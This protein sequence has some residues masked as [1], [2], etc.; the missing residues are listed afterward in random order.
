MQQR[1]FAAKAAHQGRTFAPRLG[2][3]RALAPARADA[4]ALCL[5]GMERP[6]L[7]SKARQQ[8]CSVLAFR[9]PL[10]R[11]VAY[12]LWPAR[13]R[14]TLHR[15]CAAFLEQH[16][17]KCQSCG[18]GDFVA[19]HRFAVTSTQDGG[20]C[21]SPAQQG[22]FCSW[23]ALVLAGGQLKRNRIHDT[24]GM[25]CTVLRSPGPPGAQ[26]CVLGIGWE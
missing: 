14:G 9:V 20:S 22:D 10:L 4:K 5:A 26:G 25:L 15:K 19:F 16:A 2:R 12:E 6:C 24:E 1:W 21:Q 11:E 17:H 3:P 13:Q 8:Q 18:R 7:S 23:G